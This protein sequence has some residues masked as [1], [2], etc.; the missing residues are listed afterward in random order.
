MNRPGI[1][2]GNWRWRYRAEML[3]ESLLDR[4]GDFTELYERAPAG[5]KTS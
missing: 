4:L 1:P 5:E 2:A 3:T